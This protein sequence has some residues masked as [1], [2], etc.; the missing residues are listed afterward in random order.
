MPVIKRVPKVHLASEDLVDVRK[1]DA[2]IVV[3]RADQL[4]ELICGVPEVLNAWF[5]RHFEVWSAYRTN[6]IAG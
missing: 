3:K 1:P 6:E 5:F 2:L 4:R